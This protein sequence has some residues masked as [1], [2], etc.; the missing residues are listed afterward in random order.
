VS[1]HFGPATFKEECRMV[2]IK[3]MSCDYYTREQWDKAAS[4]IAEM[5]HEHVF[6]RHFGVCPWLVERYFVFFGNEGP[7]NVASMLT[8]VGIEIE[9]IEGMEQVGVGTTADGYSWAI[10]VNA[11][12]VFAD[13]T[14][15]VCEIMQ[16]AIERA[17]RVARD[18]LEDKPGNG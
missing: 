2:T 3:Q 10:I 15:E 14:D 1:G 17:W 7:A 11:E 16:H 5:L 8:T 4:Q 12:N 6:D 9:L 13:G 18:L